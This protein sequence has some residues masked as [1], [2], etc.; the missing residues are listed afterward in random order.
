VSLSS[1]LFV[2]SYYK[3]AY[4]YGGPARS[5]PALCEGLGKTGIDVTVF[6][7][8]ANGHQT[9]DVPLSQPLDVDGVEVWYYPINT[10]RNYNFASRQ[11]TKALLD[12]ITEFDV[13]I[14][15]SVWGQLLG[16]VHAASRSSS[17]PYVVSLRGQLTTWAL[18]QKFLKKKIYFTLFGRRFLNAASALHC[19]NPHEAEQAEI[20]K[21]KPQVF[22]VPNGIDRVN[23][24]RLSRANEFCQKHHIPDGAQILLYLGRLHPN[25]NPSLC[26][27]VL[28]EISEA[29]P[30]TVL[31]FAGPENG[32][33]C[34][35]LSNYAEKLGVGSR[36]R[37]TGLLEGDETI[38]AMDAA[39]VSLIPS[40]VNESFGMSALESLAA[41]VPVVASNL[42]P[43]ASWAADHDAALAVE[44]D[45]EAFS[46]AVYQ[47]LSDEDLR[48][49]IS[50]NGADFV[51]DY[52]DISLVA[53]Q[54]ADQLSSI[55]CS[56]KPLNK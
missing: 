27:E 39:S 21:L 5:I 52:F 34:R 16:T 8:N 9:L 32:V 30:E 26:I 4:I 46:K 31:I 29:Y 3:P 18:K 24:I 42:V 14:A 45:H 56:G 10:G 13:V 23:F 12:R 50:E 40:V 55:T 1:V 51:K 11:K 41:G 54:M 2:T 17:V 25:K 28:A 35:E 38:D 53:R 7:T 15:D 47:L 43:V 49:R 36:I 48:K 22:V 19:T 33:T 6:T 20:L 37:F 44:P